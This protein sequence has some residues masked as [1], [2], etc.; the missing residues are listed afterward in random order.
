[1]RAL[2]QVA[3]GMRLQLDIVRRLPT[4]LL[5]LITAPLFSAIFMSLVINEDATAR[6]DAAVIGPGLMSLWLISLSVAAAM[7]REDRFAG[8]LELFLSTSATL[9]LVV[10]GR[11]LSLSIVGM[12]AFAESW[13]VARFAFGIHIPVNHIGLVVLAL[14]VTMLSSSATAT[15]LTSAFVLSRNLHVFQNSMSYPVYILGGVVVPLTSLPGWLQPVS[16]VVYLSW[17]ADLLRSAMSAADPQDVGLDIAMALG[18]G[19]IALATAIALTNHILGILRRNAS[20][21]LA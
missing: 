9:S 10:L 18:L 19:A 14:V 6:V 5:V 11:I 17:C 21:G 3:A 8:R 4:Q 1:M 12:L 16:K 13:L 15:L 7:L 2:A 20:A